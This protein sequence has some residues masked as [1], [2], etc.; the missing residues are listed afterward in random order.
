MTL[1]RFGSRRRPKTP[2]IPAILLTIALWPP[3]C[4]TVVVPQGGSGE[5][6]SV[7]AIGLV[8][9][10][11]ELILARHGATRVELAVMPT[12]SADGTERPLACYSLSAERAVCLTHDIVDGKDQIVEIEV[13][14]DMHKPVSQRTT[15]KVQSIDI[16]RP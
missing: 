3:A 9:A 11:A 13:L 2:L 8:F 15:E 7:L 1:P 4:S 14:R 6:A 5:D 12:R 10:D 16:R